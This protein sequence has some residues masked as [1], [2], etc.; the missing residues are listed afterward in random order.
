[1]SCSFK[2]TVPNDVYSNKKK[3]FVILCS[4][5]ELPTLELTEIISYKDMNKLTREVIG[6]CFF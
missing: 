2:V 1:M 3:Q 5:E 6:S 4:N